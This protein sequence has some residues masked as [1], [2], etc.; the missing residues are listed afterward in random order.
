VEGLGFTRRTSTR[1]TSP[2]F[3][4][5]S[6]DTESY[7]SWATPP[8]APRPPAEHSTFR[9]LLGARASQQDTLRS[10]C[11]PLCHHTAVAGPTPQTPT[12]KLLPWGCGGG[13]PELLRHPWRVTEQAA[14]RVA[15]LRTLC[16][17][18]VG[19]RG[20]G[21]HGADAV[22]Q[23]AGRHHQHLVP[24]LRQLARQR[25]QAEDTAGPCG[26][27]PDRVPTPGCPVWTVRRGSAIRTGCSALM[28]GNGEC[29]SRTLTQLRRCHE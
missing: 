3:R 9:P 11:A 6:M 7:C 29:L 5:S 4:S 14:W 25:H 16:A 24:A 27:A 23:L 17:G 13:P 28:A 12:C 8:A 2:T 21:Q 22:V 1:P 26:E 10:A 15:Q 18:G 19:G 20:P